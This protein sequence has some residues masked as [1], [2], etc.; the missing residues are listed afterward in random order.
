VPALLSVQASDYT[1]NVNVAYTQL[2]DN[3]VP[4]GPGGTLAT[5]GSS[6]SPS[7]PTDGF[8]IPNSGSITVDVADGENLFVAGTLGACNP[9]PTSL[10]RSGCIVLLHMTECAA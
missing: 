9:V 7:S 10:H 6:F 5:G 4:N 2:L 1:L 3:G 8:V